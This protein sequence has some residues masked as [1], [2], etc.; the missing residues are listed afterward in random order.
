MFSD[1]DRYVEF[2]RYFL[3]MYRD[4]LQQLHDGEH[5]DFVYDELAKI[6]SQSPALQSLAEPGAA[7][8]PIELRYESQMV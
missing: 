3:A 2:E 5:G 6:G 4:Y 8:S 7:L 1:I